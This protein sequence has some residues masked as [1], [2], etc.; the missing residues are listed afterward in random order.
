MDS[1]VNNKNVPDETDDFGEILEKAR[2][3]DNYAAEVIFERYRGLVRAKSRSYFLIGADTEDLI[4]EGMLGLY[5]A[6]RDYKP[7]KHASFSAFADLCVTRQI[8]TAI[9]TAT[10]KKHLPLNSYIPLSA[11]ALDNEDGETVNPA[12]I[13]TS[14]FDPEA[15]LIDRERG[16]A[17][18]NELKKLLSELEISVLSLYLQGMP[19]A[20]I[21]DKLNRPEKSIDN[22]FQRAKRKLEKQ[23]ATGREK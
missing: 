9:K 20:E 23:L 13:E 3:G 16:A 14:V 18:H 21:S 22:A 19:Y 2:L 1:N 10:R 8:I 5:K 4:Q 15:M 6:I 12:Q 11:Q 17:F 7:E